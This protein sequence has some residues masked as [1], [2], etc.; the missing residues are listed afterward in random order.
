MTVKLAD[1]AHACG[2]D[3]ST[4]SRALR[5]DPRVKPDTQ[6]R[7]HAMAKKMGYRPNLLARSLA[8][9]KTNCIAIV[10]HGL[11]PGTDNMLFDAASRYLQENGFVSM[12]MAHH[13]DVDQYKRLVAQLG[14]G[15][16]DAAIVIAGDHKE[17]QA[18]LKPLIQQMPVVCLDRG[19]TGKHAVTVSS[20]HTAAV[21]HLV[22]QCRDHGATKFIVGFGEHNTAAKQRFDAAMNVISEKDV[23]LMDD[24]KAKDLLAIKQPCGLLISTQYHFDQMIRDFPNELQSLELYV[25][26]F[27]AWRGD[28]YPARKVFM[29]HQDFEQMAKQAVELCKQGIE[30][31][32]QVL[33]SIAVPV[34]SF[35]EQ[36]SRLG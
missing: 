19:L 30:H 17:D 8:A 18:I 29:A 15:L 26:C 4:A 13:G 25:G 16:V 10:V 6:K 20:E 14:Q 33:P 31:S 32:S 35:E 12:V 11:Q 24:I 21:E 28:A 2:V 34:K 3:I 22:K 7:V 5:A 27:D 1:I 9:G 36:A 23:L